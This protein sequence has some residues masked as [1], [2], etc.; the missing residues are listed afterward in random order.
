[1]QMLLKVLVWLIRRLHF[2]RNTS[3]WRQNCS[4]Y[5]L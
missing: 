2:S 4:M 3:R 5:I 1:M